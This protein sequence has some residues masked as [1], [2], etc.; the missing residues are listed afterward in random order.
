MYHLR[1][2]QTQSG[3]VSS[4]PYSMMQS[5]PWVVSNQGMFQQQKT[6]INAL[7][8]SKYNPQ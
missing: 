8:H 5:D 3:R 4:L 7:K 1:H 2:F 6:G